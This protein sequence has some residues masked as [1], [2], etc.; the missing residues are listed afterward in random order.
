M[1]QVT[2]GHEVIVEIAAHGKGANRVRESQLRKWK[3][4]VR[5]GPPRLMVWLLVYVVSTTSETLQGS[6][7][8]VR[9]K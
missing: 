8:Y 5:A 2:T 6:V 3:A 4:R 9:C 7:R 1:L